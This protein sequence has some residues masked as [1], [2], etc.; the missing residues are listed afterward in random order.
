MSKIEVLRVPDERIS[1]KNGHVRVEIRHRTAWYEKAT[2]TY[3]HIS[4]FDRS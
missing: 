4:P 3:T 2:G 1:T